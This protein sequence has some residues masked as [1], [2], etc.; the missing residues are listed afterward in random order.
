MRIFWVL[1]IAIAL[2]IDVALIV[3]LVSL[4]T[5]KMNTPAT[6]VK[7]LKHPLNG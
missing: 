1:V 5:L 6:P 7:T 3:Q 2:V 4:L